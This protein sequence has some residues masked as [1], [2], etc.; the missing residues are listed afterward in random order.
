MQLLGTPDISDRSE[1]FRNALFDPIVAQHKLAIMAEWDRIRDQLEVNAFVG[2]A[3][4]RTEDERKA[5]E[6]TAKRLATP[7]S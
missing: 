3:P 2:V 7:N 6:E 4:K 5:Q 1:R